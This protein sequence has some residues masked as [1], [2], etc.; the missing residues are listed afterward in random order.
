MRPR[1]IVRRGETD[2]R[3]LI[4]DN[5]KSTVAVSELSEFS[6]LNFDDALNIAN[7]LNV[8]DTKPKPP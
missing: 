8:E 3:Y 4:W 1:Y 7:R 5:D 2:T 6:E